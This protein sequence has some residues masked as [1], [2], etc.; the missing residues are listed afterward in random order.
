M[1]STVQSVKANDDVTVMKE[2]IQRLQ[3]ATRWVTDL[4]WLMLKW[5]CCDND[6]GPY[7]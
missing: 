5:V 2:Q 6:L 1:H 7:P 3:R 4:E